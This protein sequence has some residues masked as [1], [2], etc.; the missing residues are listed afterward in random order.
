[1][2][3]S[4]HL[5]NITRCIS[6]LQGAIKT[7]TKII[8]ETVT[9]RKAMMARTIMM[10]ILKL[11]TILL[12]CLAVAVVLILLTNC[13]KQAWMR[14]RYILIPFKQKLVKTVVSLWLFFIVVLT[15]VE[16]VM[17]FHPGNWATPLVSVDTV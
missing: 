5:Q 2:V 13:W 8:S 17:H 4:S 12:I 7:S 9:L 16:N 1:M 14:T 3:Q 10:V 11:A 15:F 6:T